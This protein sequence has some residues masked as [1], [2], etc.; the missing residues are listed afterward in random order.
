MTDWKRHLEAQARSGLTAAEYCRREKLTN[1][2]FLYWRSKEKTKKTG[3]FVPIGGS[4]SEQRFEVQ[5][6]EGVLISLPV[7]FYATALKRLIEVL[8]S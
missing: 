7:D 8:N 4:Q 2:Q 6:K 1:S 3:Q 5:V